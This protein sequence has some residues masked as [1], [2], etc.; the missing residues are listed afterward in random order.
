MVGFIF[1]LK[2]AVTSSVGLG[3][4]NDFVF[5]KFGSI[6]SVPLEDFVYRIK[7]IAS[8]MEVNAYGLIIWTVLLKA[9]RGC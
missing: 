6:P 9:P 1:F 7:K 4:Q 2:N 8:G 5:W 3:I